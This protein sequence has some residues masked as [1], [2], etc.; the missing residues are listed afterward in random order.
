VI[1]TLPDAGGH[2]P[3]SPAGWMPALILALALAAIVLMA[4]GAKRRAGGD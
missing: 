2:G 3:Q 1:V 4:E